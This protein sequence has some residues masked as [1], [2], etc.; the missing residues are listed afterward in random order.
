MRSKISSLPAAIQELVDDSC[1]K[2]SDWNAKQLNI[3]FDAEMKC[4]TCLDDGRGMVCSNL[5]DTFQYGCDSEV[6]KKLSFYGVGM[7][8]ALFYLGEGCITF[9]V[10]K[11][12]DGDVH[13]AV[14]F[15]GEAVSNGEGLLT[16]PINFDYLDEF[17]EWL[18]ENNVPLK[19][20]SLNDWQAWLL[21]E[22]STMRIAESLS[23][24]DKERAKMWD[25]QSNDGGK[26]ESNVLVKRKIK[27][28]CDD[29]RKCFKAEGYK[30]GHCND[31]MMSGRGRSRREQGRVVGRWEIYDER[32]GIGSAF[33]V[34]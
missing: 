31:F 19:D 1:A 2:G 8:D 23:L 14:L 25:K 7:K 34:N 29:L 21:K 26:V 28:A 4:L 5:A 22:D 6:Q 24:N 20:C 15:S 10:A 32:D 16:I 30:H 11:D 13:R 17:K 18:A 12:T 3:D 33:F 9:S 27:R